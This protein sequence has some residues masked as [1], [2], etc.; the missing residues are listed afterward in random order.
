MWDYEKL[1]IKNGMENEKK[2]TL[3]I[4]TFLIAIESDSCYALLHYSGVVLFE[5]IG[6]IIIIFTNVYCDEF[7]VI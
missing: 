3:N 1:W 5:E 2:S 4:S 7:I 6:I